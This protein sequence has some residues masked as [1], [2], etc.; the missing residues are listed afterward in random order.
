MAR[1]RQNVTASI[2]PNAAVVEVRQDNDDVVLVLSCASQQQAETVA[3][4]I[5]NG[6]G[7]FDTRVE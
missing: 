6:C 2:K 7:S 1:T 5:I 3:L 4:A